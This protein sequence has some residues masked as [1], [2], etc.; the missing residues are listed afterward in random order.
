[1]AAACA[2]L[3]PPP[4]LVVGLGSPTSLPGSCQGD[5]LTR[6]THSSLGP[7]QREVPMPSCTVLRD[8]VRWRWHQKTLTHESRGHQARTAP[9]G[10]PRL[11]GTHRVDRKPISAQDSHWAWTLMLLCA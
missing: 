1:V 2:F 7:S 8:H 10:A 4:T 5:P 3:Q 11:E 6:S 9:G